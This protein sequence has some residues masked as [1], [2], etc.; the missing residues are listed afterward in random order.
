MGVTGFILAKVNHIDGFLRLL[1]HN[2]K[3]PRLK[4]GLFCYA[5]FASLEP[6]KSTR[7]TL[8]SAIIFY[9]HSYIEQGTAIVV[10][11]LKITKTPNFRKGF[12][13]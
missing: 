11:A 3:N 10:F 4:Q 8:F 6:E 12:T 2:I 9:K 13:V 5:T 7:I 1:L